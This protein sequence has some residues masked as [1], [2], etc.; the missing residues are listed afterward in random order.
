MLR[1]RLSK[2]SRRSVIAVMAET[3]TR[4]TT[5]STPW[6]AGGG[7]QPLSGGFSDE[8]CA[9]NTIT[10]VRPRPKRLERLPEQYFVSLLGRVAAAAA[11][12]GPPVV[13]LGRGNPE[14]GPPAHVV[15]ALQASAARPDGHGYAP[16]RGLPQLREAIARRYESHYGVRLDPEREVAVV[17]GTKTAIV[18]LALSLADR[19]D[20]ILL[21]DPYYPD[22]P[23]GVALAG[24]E[25][26]LVRLEP[27]S[28]YQPDLEAAPPAA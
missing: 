15:E 21:P 23:S 1:R 10:S 18:E 17:P 26:G 7:K 4:A 2:S 24:A 16:L 20:R 25:L 27:E 14:V 11:E 28:G 6:S 22:Y 8:R 5:P 13:D 19:G 3:S 12:E 9:R